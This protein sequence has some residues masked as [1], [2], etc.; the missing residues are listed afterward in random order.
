MTGCIASGLVL[1]NVTQ[2]VGAGGIATLE[3]F[4][5]ALVNAARNVNSNG[6]E[7]ERNLSS[8]DCVRFRTAAAAGSGE[9]PRHRT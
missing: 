6:L 1:K 3:K 4:S 7:I 5:V 8:I 9:S 2:S